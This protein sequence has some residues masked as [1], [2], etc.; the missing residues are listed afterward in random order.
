MHE[1]AS[2]LISILFIILI[3]I[4]IIN[5]SNKHLD[6]KKEE[7][8]FQQ[9]RD[10][11]V[12]FTARNIGLINADVIN[13]VRAGKVESDQVTTD[14]LNMTAPDSAICFAYGVSGNDVQERDQ[15]CIGPSEIIDFKNLG[16]YITSTETD[17]NARLATIEGKCNNYN[18][19]IRQQLG[20]LSGSIDTSLTNTNNIE[21]RLTTLENN[22]A[23]R[24]AEFRSQ[25]NTM[26]SITIPGITRSVQSSL[27]D[28]DGKCGGLQKEIQTTTT[29]FETRCARLEQIAN[30]TNR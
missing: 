20:G 17:V 22:T 30:Q 26:N 18:T 24:V 7:E 3:T 9:P 2:W 19:A 1:C 14:L 11:L 15:K 29:E 10:L 23:N 8:L 28:I 25:I 6:L 5:T 4:V 13:N 16:S 27:I 12:D 21:Q